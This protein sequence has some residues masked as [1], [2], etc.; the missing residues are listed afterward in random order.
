MNVA[1]RDRA[2]PRADAFDDAAQEQQHSVLVPRFR[3]APARQL[4]AS[5]M[6]GTLIDPHRIFSIETFNET[7]Q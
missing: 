1:P 3:V 7:V 6:N 5:A 2:G 4:V